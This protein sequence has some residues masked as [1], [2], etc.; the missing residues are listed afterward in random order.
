MDNE[1]LRF[2]NLNRTERNDEK[3]F[4][5]AEGGMEKGE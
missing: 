3:R 5:P 4:L 1:P 2:E